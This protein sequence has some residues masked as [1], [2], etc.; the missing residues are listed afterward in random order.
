MDNSDLNDLDGTGDWLQ[1]LRTYAFKHDTGVTTLQTG[2]LRALLNRLD[3]AENRAIA[4]EQIHVDYRATEADH[5]RELKAGAALGR[6]LQLR[7]DEFLEAANETFDMVL[8][9]EKKLERL[10]ALLILL[11]MNLEAEYQHYNERP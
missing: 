11:Q 6:G 9:D 8:S 4:A 7:A 2:S 10:N 1:D 5:S 3:S